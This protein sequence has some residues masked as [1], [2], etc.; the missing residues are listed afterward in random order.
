MGIATTVLAT[1]ETVV[2]PPFTVNVVLSV[3][4][5]VDTLVMV[6]SVAIVVVGVT[7]VVDE[8]D[9]TVDTGIAR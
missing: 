3:S 1:I 6:V 2:T 5:K 9:V 8:V 7:V 4:V